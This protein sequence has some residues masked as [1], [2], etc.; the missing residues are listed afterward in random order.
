[1]AVL[2][3][4][5]ST[6]RA[7][8]ITPS[9]IK[10]I[11][12]T[13][14]AAASTV[15]SPIVVTYKLES[16]ASTTA[17]AV[18][19]E[20]STNDGSSYATCTALTSDSRHDGVSSLSADP[21][22]DEHTFIWDSETDVGASVAGT[23][24]NRIRIRASDGTAY[25]DYQSGDAF[26]IDHIPTAQITSPAAGSTVGDNV[27]V[28]YT[29]GTNRTGVTFSTTLEYSTNGGSSY[30]TATANTSDSAHSGTSSLSSGSKTFVWNTNT[31]LGASFNNTI[32]L[33]LRINDGTN[34]SAYA[35]RQITVGMI[36]SVTIASPTAA[37]VGTAPLLINY[38]ITTYRTGVTFAPTV[39]YS[40][41]EGSSW[42]SATASTGHSSHS[43]A[44]GLSSGAKTYVWNVE[45]N[46]GATLNNSTMQVRVR[47][48]DGTNNSAYVT[49]DTFT[50]SLIPT[51]QI[52][53]PAVASTQGDVALLAYTIVSNR[54]SPSFTATA[55]FSTNNGTSYNTCTALTSHSS[56][57][58]LSGLSEGS[59]TFAWDADADL[60]VS[61]SS[62]A[63]IRLRINDGTNASSY[64]T[65]ELTIDLI[66]SVNV[67]APSSGAQEST[68]VN[69]IYTISSNRTSPSF[70]LTAEYS[71]DNSSFSTCTA[72]TGGIHSGVSGLSTGSKTFVWN[73]GAD[74]STVFLNTAYLRLRVNDGTNNSSYD[75]L[76]VNIDTLPDAPTLISP[77]D[78]YFDRADDAPEFI[79]QLPEDSGSNRLAQRIEFDN[80]SDFSSK[81]LDHNS[82]DNLSGFRHQIDADDS[83]KRDLNIA[84][85]VSDV[86]ATSISGST[87]SFANLTD[88]HTETALPSSLT[89]PQILLINKA[90][91]RSYIPTSSI[92]S[93]GFTLKKSAVGIDTNGKVDL[94]IFADASGAFDTYWVDLTLTADTTYTY[95]SAPFA[96]DLLS[97][98]IPS[99]LTNVRPEV[100]EG[101][102]RPVYVS[103]SSNTGFTLSIGATGVDTT[104][105]CRVCLRQTA[106]ESYQHRELAVS[107]AT[108]SYTDF[109]ASL[110]DATNSNAAWPDYVA[111]MTIALTERSDRM[112]ILSA[113][114]ND[115]IS[116]R[117]SGV[118]VSANASIDVHGVGRATGL[119]PFYTDV[120]RNGVPDLFEGKRCK[121]TL[122][123]TLSDDTYYWRVS[124][125]NIT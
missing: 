32:D 65:R 54:T 118:G 82:I 51:L 108:A 98:T 74:V 46:A 16:D 61:Y 5:T 88:E 10:A 69:V 45:S 3:G 44:S 119:L 66:P 55:E 97:R 48:N 105:S 41:N 125:G 80:A 93:T 7:R 92:S 50:L 36:P 100:L 106:T 14:P 84:Y 28:V 34:N 71:T 113:L 109:S 101:S 67:T 96:T 37:T 42:A 47:V 73:A 79:W 26:T 90:D 115:E 99:T 117:K 123:D 43:G 70:T 68:P 120:S 102:D 35:T 53:S 124:C 112:A 64:Y 91:R 22:A 24:D 13:A 4:N 23:T 17:T 18:Q 121:Y 21:D 9:N 77:V 19:I 72:V 25:S 49:S 122:T 62:T 40:I 76:T 56:H 78:G 59:N 110:T 89:N 20:Y 87:I 8:G 103:A 11:A 60:G 31:D 75:T 52:T 94:I 12:I 57:S 85:Y 81:A 58:G 39:E 27:N 29:I 95:G 104:A 6:S 116:I 63:I 33:R 38:N 111:G 114:Y 15:G 107:S 2:Y 1:M 86:N 83:N 30:S